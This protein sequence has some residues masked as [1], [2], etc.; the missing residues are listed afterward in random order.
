MKS[1]GIGFANGLVR[2]LELRASRGEAI[3]PII[4]SRGT[5]RMPTGRQICIA[6]I[7]QMVVLLIELCL[8]CLPPE[9]RISFSFFFF[10]LTVLERIQREVV[11]HSSELSLRN[12]PT[13]DF[14]IAMLFG[15]QICDFNLFGSDCSRSK[16]FEMSLGFYEKYIKNNCCE[17]QSTPG[18]F[19]ALSVRRILVYTIVFD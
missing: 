17:I 7:V 1:P 13:R 2:T 8:S 9:L 16:K 6:S 14:V 4:P 12:L 18:E 19:S 15:A 11:R 3:T 10:F 5:E